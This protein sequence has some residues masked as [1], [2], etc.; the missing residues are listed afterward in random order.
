MKYVPATADRTFSAVD[1]TV[2][3]ADVD[4]MLCELDEHAVEEALRITESGGG[5][6]T[7]V[8][9]GPEEAAD[10]IARGLQMGAHRGVHITDDALHGSDA[11][12]TSLVLAAAVRKTG[13]DIVLCGMAST[14]GAMGVVPAMLAERLGVPQLTLAS[15]VTV[16][17][18][19]VTIRRES[20][21]AT[22]HIEASGP[23]VLSVTDR[24]NE[25]RYPSFKGIM[26]AKKKPV[27]TWSLA[28]LG[29][30][31]EVGLAAAGTTVSAFAARPG[32]TAGQ[33]VS[34]EGEGGARLVQYLVAQK[35]V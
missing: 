14:D 16:E 2:E 10:A 20:P 31:S 18:D 8:T 30:A 12:A 1:N 28:D 13:Y 33:I 9:A 29:I 34:D 5:E 6:V 21:T 26:A 27:E 23:L 25:P 15:Q 24:S 17:G 3:R 7:V 22:E 4:G 32:R 11:A 19:T 35:L